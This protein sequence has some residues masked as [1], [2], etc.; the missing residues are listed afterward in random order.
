[1][2]CKTNMCICF[3]PN[4]FAD[5]HP[6]IV[7]EEDNDDSVTGQSQTNWKRIVACIFF[8][9][10]YI[11]ENVIGILNYTDHPNLNSKLL[12]TQTVL[13]I[14]NWCL[15]IC[16]CL[17]GFYCIGTRFKS[18][19]ISDFTAIE[20]AILL[21]TLSI[22]VHNMIT[23]WTVIQTPSKQCNFSDHV[24]LA[25]DVVPDSTE[26]ALQTSFLIT[27]SHVQVRKE[28]ESSLKL[29]MFLLAFSN[30]LTWLKDSITVKL[31]DCD[32]APIQCAYFGQS[33][34][35]VIM[36]FLIP[37]FLFFR[38]NSA[39]MFSI[40]YNTANVVEWVSPANA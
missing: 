27:A 9:C 8:I 5:A 20:I 14:V 10:P 29:T 12:M 6:P 40:L 31:Y 38:I 23:I 33:N 11:A 2:Q 26:V 30:F 4:V 28:R 24:L 13:R 17:F 39:I 19:S 25:L 21:S 32:I 22:F 3:Q 7:M 36:H 18:K 15:S 34:W 35:I 1:M 16:C 37:V